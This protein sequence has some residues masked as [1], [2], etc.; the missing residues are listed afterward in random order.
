MYEISTALVN[1]SDSPR[2]NK[3]TFGKIRSLDAG[4]GKSGDLIGLLV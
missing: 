2:K 3:R 1:S 4:E